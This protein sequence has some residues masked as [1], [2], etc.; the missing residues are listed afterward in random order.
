MAST[1]ETM[2]GSTGMVMETKHNQNTIIKPQSQ[3]QSIKSYYSNSIQLG[4]IK[5]SRSGWLE[6]T[7]TR[8]GRPS[9][10]GLENARRL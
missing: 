10:T 9:V 5:G 3:N 8:C 1:L 6:T 2:Q 7:Y 4:S